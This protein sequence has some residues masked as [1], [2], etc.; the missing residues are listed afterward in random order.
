MAV[1]V[2]STEFQ[3]DN[4]N[5]EFGT[6]SIWICLES[7]FTYLQNSKKHAIIILS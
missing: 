4:S 5:I 2:D 6:R 7:L 1:L 3:I